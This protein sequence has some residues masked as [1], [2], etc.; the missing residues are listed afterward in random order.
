VPKIN[1]RK[2]KIRVRR[3]KN[4][5]SF[6]VDCGLINGSRKRRS[7]TT[8]TEAASFAKIIENKILNEGTAALSLSEEVRISAS[9]ANSILAPFGANIKDAAQY[10]VDHFL[11]FET[12][13]SASGIA[14][15]C[16][17]SAKR[18]R[19]RE[20]TVSDLKNRLGVFC[21]TFGDQRLCD[22]TQSDIEEW[23]HENDDWGPR[24][25]VDYLTKVSQLFN[26]AIK[27]KWVSINLVKPNAVKEFRM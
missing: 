6:E 10:Y 19:R 25:K 14:E 9:Q 5:D 4:Q 24:A 18:N 1:N 23:I 8:R 21:E 13:P 15:Q 3:Q 27:K 16:V 12:A 17:K 7:F 2:W 26:F 20:R 11:T 22:I